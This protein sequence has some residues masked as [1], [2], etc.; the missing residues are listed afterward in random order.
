MSEGQLV[1]TAATVA[2]FSRLLLS[3]DDVEFYRRRKRKLMY[4]ILYS[5]QA[6]SDVSMLLTLSLLA[7][8][9]PVH[10]IS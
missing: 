2:H 5:T 1:Y 8:P 4:I 7:V 3:R 9:P 10:S 6:Y